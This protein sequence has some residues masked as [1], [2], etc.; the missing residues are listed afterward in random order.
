M[1]SSLLAVPG[2]GHGPQMRTWLPRLG[3]A[4]AP[5]GGAAGSLYPRAE[6]AVPNCTGVAGVTCG[7]QALGGTGIWGSGGGGWY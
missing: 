3:S 1:G 6:H 2:G 7:Q 5:G 4:A